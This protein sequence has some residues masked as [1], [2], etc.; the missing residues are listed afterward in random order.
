[1]P[2]KKRVLKRPTIAPDKTFGSVL[3]SKLTNRIMWDGKKTAAVKIIN[4][5]L[6][7]ASD[8]LKVAPVEL[9][10]SVVANVQP[11]V[12][13]K[14]VRVGGANYQVPMEPYPARAL[15]LGLTWIVDGARAIKGKPMAE[16]L[17]TILIQSF[18]NEGPAVAKRNTVHQTAAGNKAFAHLASRV[19]KKKS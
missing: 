17:S 5:A 9:L 10:E 12:E 2:R 3:V 18:N 11:Q 16:R 6:T 1:M 19:S 14:S 4:E 13:V 7:K 8:E 15:R